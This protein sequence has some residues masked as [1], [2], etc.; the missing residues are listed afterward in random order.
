MAGLAIIFKICV[1]F[2]IL[3]ENLVFQNKVDGK[4]KTIDCIKPFIIKCWLETV[5]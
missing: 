1:Y 5:L 2:P 4:S 3:F